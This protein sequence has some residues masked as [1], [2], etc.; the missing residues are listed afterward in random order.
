M[1]ATR[2]RVRPCRARCSPRSVGRV[3]R[4]SSPTCSTLI[5]RLT[6]SVSSPLGPLTVTR[7]GSMA[8]VTPVGTGMGCRPMRDIADAVLPDSGH[9][10]ATDPL[11]AGLVAGHDAL[12]RGDDRRAHTPLHAGDV[13][14]IDIGPLTGAR[15]PLQPGDDGAA[16]VGV[17]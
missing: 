15:H 8:M 16:L 12:G 9:D 6:R 1:L 14:V 4:T 2:V 11:L 3:T 10:L 7:S 17:L 13:A 5:S